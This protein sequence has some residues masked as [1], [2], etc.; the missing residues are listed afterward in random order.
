VSVIDDKTKERVI[1]DF[2]NMIHKHCIMYNNM[3]KD[4]DYDDIVQEVKTHIAFKLDEYDS[5]KSSVSTYV[6]TVIR[7]KLENLSKFSRRRKRNFNVKDV[8]VDRYD[9]GIAELLLGGQD[10]RSDYENEVLKIAYRAF[11]GES[12]RNKDI[13]KRIFRGERYENIAK[14]YKISTGQIGNIKNKFIKE[15]KSEL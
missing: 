13:L 10:E 1:I 12:D 15:V 4:M 7:N 2:E 5:D 9:N 11:D 6:Y 3:I 8:M 14:D